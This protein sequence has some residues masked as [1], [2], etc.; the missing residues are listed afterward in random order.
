MANLSFNFKNYINLHADEWS[1]IDDFMDRN[2]STA[3][4]VI[5]QHNHE[6]TFHMRRFIADLV[7]GKLKRDPNKKASTFRRDYEIYQEIDSLIN[8]AVKKNEKC[9]LISRKELIAARMFLTVDAVDKMYRRGKRAWEEYRDVEN[10]ECNELTIEL[11]REARQA[12]QDAYIEWMESMENL[13]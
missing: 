9:T 10:H 7:T 5:I 12:E 6:I 11:D 13:N 2:D 3:L 1:A 4:S 8:E